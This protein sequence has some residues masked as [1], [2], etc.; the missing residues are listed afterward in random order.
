[1]SPS[2]DDHQEVGRSSFRRCYHHPSLLL[3]QSR[4]WN[5]HP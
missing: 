2:E 4:F 5:S 1:M 3:D